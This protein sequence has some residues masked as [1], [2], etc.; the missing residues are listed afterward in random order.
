MFIIQWRD[1][2]CRMLLVFPEIN[3]L[4]LKDE[5]LLFN[6]IILYGFRE[7]LSFG[8]KRIQDIYLDHAHALQKVKI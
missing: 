1:T 7:G 4:K 6:H 3:V 2:L 5:M 8:K